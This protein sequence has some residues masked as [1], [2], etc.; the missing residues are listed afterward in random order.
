LLLQKDNI[1]SKKKK[2]SEDGE[3]KEPTFYPENFTSL[4]SQAQQWLEMLNKSKELSQQESIDKD[5][6]HFEH[7]RFGNIKYHVFNKDVR[8]LPEYIPRRD[9]TLILANIPYGVQTKGCEHN[10][11]AWGEKKLGD[12]VR[13]AKFVT[14]AKEFRFIII[15]S[16]EQYYIVRKVLDK[17][18]N[19]EYNNGCW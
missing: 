12:M 9:Y 2:T 17:E 3:D 14:T 6:V 13:A 19:A 5:L 4:I 7:P 18:T 11:L 1:G 15:H 8:N 16:V 10:D